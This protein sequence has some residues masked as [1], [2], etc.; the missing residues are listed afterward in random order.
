M[1]TERFTQLRKRELSKIFNKKDIIYV[2]REIV[3]NQLRSLDLKD[4]YD[5]YD[6]NYNI[7]ERANI[8]RHE[9]LSGNYKTSQPLVYRIEKKL[10]ICRHLIIPQPS[11]ALIFQV[12]VENLSKE[13][14]LNQPSINAFYSRDKHK[15]SKKPH[16]SDDYNFN[17]R[18]Q[19]K[20]LQKKIYRFNEEK[21]LIVVT[22][23]ANY[24]DSIN[25]YELRKVFTSYSKINEVVI[26]LMFKIIEEFSWKPDYLP[27]SSR[28]LPTTNLEGIRLLAHSFLFEVDKVIKNKTNNS[29]TRWMDDITIGVDSRKDGIEILSIVSDMLKSRGL[30]LNLSKTNIYNEKDAFYHFQIEANRYIDSIEN[31]KINDSRYKD[32]CKELD[33][34]FKKHFE[35]TGAKYWDKIAKRYITMYGKLQYNA[36]LKELPNIYIKFPVLRENLIY[37]LKNIG[38]NELTSENVLNIIDNIDVFDD[39]SLY[40]LSSLV[41]EWEIPINLYSEKFLN[42]FER[43]LI[44]L[45][46]SRGNSSDFYSIIWFKAKYNDP[47]KLL[48]FLQKYNNKWQT[49]AFLRR[50]VTAVLAR[51]LNIDKK[52]T[53]AL[54]QNQITSGVANTVTLANQIFIFSSIE[55]L[56]NKL[57]YYLFPK[58]LQKPYPLSKFL[59]LCSVL[60]SEHIRLNNQVKNLVMKSISDP[61]YLK[62]IEESYN[63]K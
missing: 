14:L 53:E 56:D 26:D 7:E 43:R 38:Y 18:S 9:L 30:A 5:H 35:D 21:N 22:D 48:S 61:Y 23:L 63:I 19:W 32:I 44:K 37:L 46:L 8:I 41:T 10:G 47:I 50:Q 24:Y 28:G 11:D 52:S 17:W 51:L 39:R 34:R 36:I 13:I 1:Q 49:D 20:K 4:L 33:E 40:Q 6:F 3:R 25:I 62:W 2:W 31:T 57:M 58:Q 59:V 15:I 27:Y 54:L 45:S 55:K 29:F 42:H 12:L 60:N 16:D